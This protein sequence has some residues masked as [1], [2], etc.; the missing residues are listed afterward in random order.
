MGH[1]KKE[2]EG[3]EMDTPK[4]EIWVLENTR[5][6]VETLEKMTK[7]YIQKKILSRGEGENLIEEWEENWGIKVSQN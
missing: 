3:R 1:K 2:G 7:V 5:K 6:R 4:D